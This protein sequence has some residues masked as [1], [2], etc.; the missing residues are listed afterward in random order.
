MERLRSLEDQQRQHQ[1]RAAPS[2]STSLADS[3]TPN[4]KHRSDGDRSGKKD[5]SR[6]SVRSE[7]WAEPDVSRASAGDD[8]LER[9]EDAM[10]ALEAFMEREERE[11]E[12]ILRRLWP[13]GAPSTVEE[14]SLMRSSMEE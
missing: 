13:R 14:L 5:H 8:Y 9:L 11:K 1:Q 6:S 4:R 2:P 3:K 7:K 10:V 12:R